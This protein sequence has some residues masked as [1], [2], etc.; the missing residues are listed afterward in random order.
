MSDRLAVSTALRSVDVVTSPPLWSTL[1]CATTSWKRL[2]SRSSSVAILVF[3]ARWAALPSSVCGVG[4]CCTVSWA[5]VWLARVSLIWSTSRL[6]RKTNTIGLS[7]PASAACFFTVDSV[8]DHS[9]R[10]QTGTSPSVIGGSSWPQCWSILLGV[11]LV[12]WVSFNPPS[13]CVD[14]LE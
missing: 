13:A 5:A 1:A 3:I 11:L 9:S 14:R 8:T 2:S 7:L 4:F 12:P 6:G 10:I